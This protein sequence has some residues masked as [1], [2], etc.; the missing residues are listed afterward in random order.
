MGSMRDII[1]KLL[2]K[3]ILLNSIA[4]AFAVVVDDG[5]GGGDAAGIVYD[6][7]NIE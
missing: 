3:S 5:G 7:M 2:Y 1:I 4:T 6:F